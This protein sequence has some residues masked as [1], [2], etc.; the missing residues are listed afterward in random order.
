[1]VHDTVAEQALTAQ[2]WD[3]LRALPLPARVLALQARFQ[4][5]YAELGARMYVEADE[6]AARD[7]ALL[8]AYR[9]TPGLS[10]IL[11]RARVLTVCAERLPVILHPEELLVGRQ[12]CNGRLSGAV[13]EE[14]SALGY[15]ATTGHIV[16]D[17]A[18]LLAHGIAGYRVL[19]SQRMAQPLTEDAATTLAGFAEALSA[20]DRF[21]TRHAE[22]AEALAATR[23][24]DAAAEWRQRAHDL[25]A[26]HDA[27]PTTFAQGLQ[28][29]WLAHIF[30]HV[31]NPSVAISFGRFD[32]Y[33]WPLLR[34]DLAAGRSDWPTAFAIV[35][36]FLLKCC[37]GEESQNVILGGMDR[38]G[39]DASNPLSLLMLAAMRRLA[40]FQP[41]LCVRLHPGASPVFLRAACELS[42]AGNG[43]PGFLNDPVVIAGLEAVG[44][45]TADARDYGVVGCYEATVPGACYPNTVLCSLHL[46]RDLASYLATAEAQQVASFDA[47][48]AG[49]LAH[50]RDNYLHDVLPGVQARWNHFREHAPS[51]FGSL[52]MRDCLTRALP[53][54]AGGA[55]SNLVGINMLGL[56]TVVDSLH[57]VRE[58]VFTR[59]AVTLAALAAAIAQDFPDEALRLRLQQVAGRYGTDSPATNDLAAQVS[60]QLAD[61]VLASRLD[62]GVRPCPSFFQFSGDIYALGMASPDGR[63]ARDLISY[64]VAPAASVATEAT[65]TLLSAAHVAQ[66]RA[67]CGCPLALSLSP[68]DLG[69]AQGLARLGQLV[70]TYFAL[71]GFHVHVNVMQ[72]ATLRAAQADPTHHAALT[73]RVSGYSA[74]FVTV[75]RQW[76][77]ALIARTER[78]R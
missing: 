24:G 57:A 13:A 61:M 59:G 28:L 53:L 69:G 36:A 52:L 40:T 44:I 29:L 76:Q 21:V 54:E 45:P 63:H 27:P 75:E 60:G 3:M 47:F 19:L 62:D 15:A 6:A 43:N 26:L 20:F 39:R 22:A 17:Y 14:A 11:R 10:A 56:G 31:E 2:L 73:I 55:V 38:A 74:R 46:V 64:G 34:D 49:W 32:Q 48:L 68:D 37:E 1:M 78:G 77:D 4:Q 72:A 58:V 18:G 7:A 66:S 67:A 23:T 50:V 8:D 16:H 33:L 12:T 41:S 35:C 71:G 65:S 25:R 5:H 9:A 70:T 42:A 51:P 30:L